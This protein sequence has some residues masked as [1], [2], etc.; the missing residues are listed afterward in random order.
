VCPFFAVRC[1]QSLPCYGLCRALGSFFA[2]LVFIAV[3]CA[4]S[5]PCG[6]HCRALFGTFAVLDFFAVRS[7]PVAR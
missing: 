1:H 2:V 4:T 7:V 6:S 5:L 3:R